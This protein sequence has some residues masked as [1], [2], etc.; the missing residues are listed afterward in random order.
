M[1]SRSCAS[2]ADYRQL[3]DALFHAGTNSGSKY[4]W[5]DTANRLHFYVIDASAGDLAPLGVLR[6]TVAVRSLD[7]S[8]PQTRGVTLKADSSWRLGQR[9]FAKFTVAN[10][11]SSVQL[12]D[13]I[14]PR[15]RPSAFDKD[16]YRFT[17]TIEGTGWSV[18]LGSQFYAMT[19]GSTLPFEVAARHT[20]GASSTAK[21]TLRAVSESDLSKAA[22]ATITLRR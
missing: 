11:G 17:A 19:A 12:P 3:N 16:V 20:S 8:G 10:T 21:V 7:G 5:E 9:Y 2:I 14:H 4:E 18:D 22:V 1:A 13:S 15:W 6:Y